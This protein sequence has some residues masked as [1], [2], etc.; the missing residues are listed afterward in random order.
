MR[1]PAYELGQNW[2]GLAVAL[3]PGMAL[4]WVT[5]GVLGHLV[6]GLLWLPALLLGAAIAPTD[7]VLSAPIPTGRLARR[8]APALLR[9]DMT[10]E[11]AINDGPP[12]HR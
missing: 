6:F 5:G 10:A 8:A 1:L 7:P 3:G 2:R 11:S 4:M 12:C 9:N